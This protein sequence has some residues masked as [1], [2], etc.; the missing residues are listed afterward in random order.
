MVTNLYKSTQNRL[1][2]A[3]ASLPDRAQAVSIIAGSSM[4]DCALGRAAP[5]LRFP[6]TRAARSPR[7][8]G[9]FLETCEEN[10]S[11][12]STRWVE[13]PVAIVALAVAAFALAV[14]FSAPTIVAGTTVGANPGPGIVAAASVAPP[15]IL[16]L[17]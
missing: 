5:D 1:Q 11:A 7:S 12:K 3:P 9:V 15:F 14:C 16:P 17:R 4:A 13:V 6:P 2:I 8:R 10:P